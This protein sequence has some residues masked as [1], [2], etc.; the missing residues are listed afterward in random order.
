MDTMRAS[1]VQTG[2]PPA[3]SQSDRKQ[4][5]NHLDTLLTKYGKT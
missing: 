5:A 1:G 4:F 2:G 3:L